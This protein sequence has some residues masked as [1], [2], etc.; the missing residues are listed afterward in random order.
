MAKP[1]YVD[2]YVVTALHCS[3]FFVYLKLKFQM[4]ARFCLYDN[5]SEFKVAMHALTIFSVRVY[6]CH[7]YF[8]SKFP[9]DS[10]R[11]MVKTKFRLF[12]GQN[13]CYIAKFEGH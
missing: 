1:T 8:W 11:E 3:L 5:T 10:V 9:I 7:D 2:I 12:K 6:Y 4:F 13:V